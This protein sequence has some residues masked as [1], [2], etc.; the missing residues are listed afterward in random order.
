MFRKMK[1]NSNKFNVLL[2]IIVSLL[3]LLF[4]L[5]ITTNVI[6]NTFEESNEN[7]KE[8]IVGKSVNFHG[9]TFS[10]NKVLIENN[11]I[12]LFYTLTDKEQKIFENKVILNECSLKAENSVNF[13][14]SIAGPTFNG[15]NSIIVFNFKDS[16]KFNRNHFN[17]S[18]EIN[19][20]RQI[21]E[22]EDYSIPLKN[23]YTSQ[24]NLKFENN[25]GWIEIV[26]CKIDGLTT[27]MT[28]HKSPEYKTVVP[29]IINSITGNEYYPESQI[30]YNN[31]N[32]EQTYKYCFINTEGFNENCKIVIKKEKIYSFENPLNIDFKV[33][34]K[35][36][37]TKVITPNSLFINSEKIQS[38]TIN[39]R[40]IMITSLKNKQDIAN[41]ENNQNVDIYYD[42]GDIINKIS[43]II[44]P[45][46]TCGIRRYFI[47]FDSPIN[48]AYN[49]I[50][51]IGKNEI[52]LK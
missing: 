17:L 41:T 38:I 36:I 15:K 32:K 22:S 24:D 12:L 43:N 42:N 13:A 44:T 37:P 35:N 26:S 30:I 50:L 21:E 27:N 28:L 34:L 25:S 40:S 29:C 1:K 45:P 48:Y 7:T 46:N 16:D 10:I 49:P 19:S 3:I 11:A 33:N 47:I 31:Q 51:K 39:Q 14:K 6:H 4:L 2:V 23:V 8:S 9:L 52:I 5:F 18:L 20:L